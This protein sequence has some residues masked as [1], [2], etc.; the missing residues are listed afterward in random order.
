MTV[1]M[2]PP[3]PQPLRVLFL[4]TH[5]SARSQIAEALLERKGRGR[6]L[7]ASTATEP[8]PRVHPLAVQVLREIGIEWN[9]RHP[10]T[11]G[12]IAGEQ[13]DFVITVCDHARESCPTLP[14]QPVFAHWGIE[15]P[16]A[17]E[18]DEAQR[19]RAF[20]DALTY[21]SRRIDLMLAIP[22]EN[23]SEAP[24]RSGSGRSE[25][26]RVPPRAPSP[27]KPSRLTIPPNPQPERT[28]C[29]SH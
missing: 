19:H 13:W 20:H 12:A 24:S 10:K 6:F 1:I 27:S 23:S 26:R 28:P 18:G 14:G 21:L 22:F 16:A 3:E 7:A 5:D 15:D 11:I 9:G 2:A 25:P 8:A 17:A 29:A 4:C